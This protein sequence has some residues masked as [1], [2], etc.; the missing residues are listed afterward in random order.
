MPRNI[1]NSYKVATPLITQPDT[2]QLPTHY[3]TADTARSTGTRETSTDRSYPLSF[4]G[5][6]GSTFGESVTPH[7]FSVLKYFGKS[8]RASNIGP[9]F[10]LTVIRESGCP[11]GSFQFPRKTRVT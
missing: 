4:T 9:Q 10:A 6:L 3:D 11:A 7:T 5:S 2:V 1:L 8:K